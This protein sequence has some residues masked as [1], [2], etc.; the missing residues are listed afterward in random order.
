ML[1]VFLDKMGATFIFHL[2]QSIDLIMVIGVEGN[3][4]GHET[5]GMIKRLVLQKI[6]Q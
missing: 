4:I 6:E 2:Y 5:T 3:F 1:E